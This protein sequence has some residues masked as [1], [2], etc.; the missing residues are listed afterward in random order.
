MQQSEDSQ[1]RLIPLRP[2]RQSAEW[3]KW[4]A[5]A[6]AVTTISGG[7]ATAFQA[8]N[9]PFAD[10]AEVQAATTKLNDDLVELRGMVIRI[11]EQQKG[12]PGAVADEIEKR[13]RRRR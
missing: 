11:E 13:S 8:I 2:P 4:A 5:I 1:S 9:W 6:A 3:K 10:K 12:M 7:G